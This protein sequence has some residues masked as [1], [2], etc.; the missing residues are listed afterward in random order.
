M[1]GAG[2]I[3]GESA[4]FS[5]GFARAMWICAALCGS[6]AVVAWRMIRSPERP[7]WLP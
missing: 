3:D 1:T 6:G 7:S 5:G 2:Q 4:A